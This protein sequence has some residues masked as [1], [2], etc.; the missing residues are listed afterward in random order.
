MAAPRDAKW[1]V[2][3]EPNSRLSL[4]YCS[5][6]V[7]GEGKGADGPVEGTEGGPSLVEI[8]DWRG[9]R[10]FFTREGPSRILRMRHAGRLE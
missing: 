8:G 6:R 1:G 10:E 9:A 2:L 5:S 3:S 4:G 7:R